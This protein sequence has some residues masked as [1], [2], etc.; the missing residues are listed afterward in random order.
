[1]SPN[2]GPR[3]T[4]VG[5]GVSDGVGFKGP[6]PFGVFFF[7]LVLC[8]LWAKAGFA[9]EPRQTWRDKAGPIPIVN[10]SP[11]QLLFLQPTPD[12]AEIL[13]KGQGMVR[14][15]TTLTNTLVS[16]QS[17]HYDV[18]V[19]MES[20]RSSLEV[21]Y[22][23]SLWLE[24]GFSV[25]VSYRWGGI[26]DRAIYDVENFYGSVRGTR[27]DEERFSFAYHVKK[28][29]KPVISGSNHTIGIG[30]IP[31]TLKAKLWDQGDLQPAASARASVKL[32]TGSKGRAFG[33]GEFDW[34]LG[35]LLEKDIKKLAVYLNADVTF[36]GE[37]YTDDGID[38]QE[39]YTLLMGLEYRFT[40][41]FSLLAQTVHMT[42]PF[43]HTGVE[44]LDRRIHELLIGFG[45]RTKG[46]F[47][48]QGGFMQDIMDSAEAGADVTF[49]FNIGMEL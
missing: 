14:L 27:E 32:P 45:Y 8:F 25:P 3:C 35:L 7:T 1:M 20:L 2:Q 30:D 43:S 33:S 15:N 5:S 48:V 10:Q 17:T 16:R 21:Y 18:S 37:A 4:V 40:D 46:R 19:D 39:F 36:P 44:P 12:R 34:G 22:G 11:L 24:L 13:P 42:R 23:I 41:Q 38:L 49:F 29:G 6:Q 28:D 31:V 47:T 9:Q 26:L